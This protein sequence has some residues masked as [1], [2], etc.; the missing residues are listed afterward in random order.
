MPRARPHQE[1]QVIADVGVAVNVDPPPFGNV[2]GELLD[3]VAVRGME[4]GKRAL[5][6]GGAQHKVEGL[7]GINRAGGL[8]F[9]AR[10]LAAMRGGGV[11]FK[12]RQGGLAG[13][14]EAE[15]YLWGNGLSRDK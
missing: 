10:V 2:S 14:Q 4:H 7:L 3:G 15:V 12:A 6:A 1:M 9:S 5:G 11:E 8:A 13:A